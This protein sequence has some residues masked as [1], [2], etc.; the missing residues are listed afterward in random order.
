MSSSFDASSFATEWVA[1][2]NS[3][4]L[5]AILSHYASQVIL[6]SPVAAKLTG[7]AS[8]TIQGKDALRRCFAKGLELFPNLEFTFIGVMRGLSSPASDSQYSPRSAPRKLPAGERVR[9]NSRILL[10]NRS[11]VANARWILKFYKTSAS[12]RT[13][14]RISSSFNVV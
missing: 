3:H 5:E 1:A 14:S 9:E 10:R 13:P 12:K 7:E 6:T 11:G 2:W 4:D 8:G